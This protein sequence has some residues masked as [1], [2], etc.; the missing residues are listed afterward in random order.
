MEFT[1]PYLGLEINIFIILLGLLIG[2]LSSTFGI[3]G[4]FLLVPTLSLLFGIPHANVSACSMTQM[5]PTSI[6]GLIPHWKKGNIVWQ[7]PATFLIGGF[8]GIEIGIM[9]IDYLKEI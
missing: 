3:G 5:I 9:M 4:G 7:I 6:F 2:T 8:A 1:L